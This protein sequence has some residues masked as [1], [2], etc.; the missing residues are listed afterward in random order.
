[1]K[2]YMLINRNNYL[3]VN[4]YLDWLL[5]DRH[6]NVETVDR[7]KFW[8]RHLLLWAME[9]PFTEAHKIKTSF[10]VFIEKADRPLA[11]ESQRKIIETA[12]AF[13]RW[14]KLHYAQEFLGLPGYW[15]EDLTSPSK[16]A[17]PASEGSVKLE[18]AIQLATLSIDRN[19]LALWRDQAAAALLFLSGARA[20]A[21]V[22][23]PISAIHLSTDQPYIGQWPNLGVH[24]KNNKG[25]NTF[26][27]AIPELLDVVCEWDGFVREKCP[28]AA[29]WYAPI[30]STWGEQCLSTRNVGYHRSNAL[31]KRLARLFER[32]GLPHKSPHKFRHGYAIYGLERCQTMGEYHALS[33]NL[34]HKSIATTD[35]VYIAMEERERGKLLAGLNRRDL[36]EPDEELRDYLSTLSKGDLLRTINLAAALLAV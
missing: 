24:T 21:V 1:M 31:N 4:K 9:I 32:T 35:K 26:L 34:M 20:S 17:I 11:P 2:D 12:R 36:S 8:L 28:P 23:L 3:W 29:P 7:Y 13:L 16:I 30:S 5:N 15:I 14:V 18:E 10:S 33:R 22:T 25:A 6:R 27:H 19:D